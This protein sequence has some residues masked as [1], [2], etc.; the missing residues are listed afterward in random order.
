[1]RETSGYPEHIR[2]TPF[3]WLDCADIPQ[4]EWLYGR[5]LIRKYVT[6]TVAPGGLGKSSLSIVEALA[7]V[8]GRRLLHDDPHGPLRV[9]LWNGEDPIDELQR[10]VMAAARHHDISRQE[11]DGRLFL[12][13]G[14]DSSLMVA[15]VDRTGVKFAEPVIEAVVDTIRAN[16]IDVFVVDPFV[17][18]HGVPENDNGAIDRVAKTWAKIADRTGAAIH[19]IHHARKT[20]GN[21]VSIEDSR[22]AV[23][24]IGAA[25]VG[26]T[27]NPMTKDEAERAGVEQRFCY[28]RVDDGKANLAPRSEDGRWFK[29]E[30]VSL[31]YGARGTNGD[32][33]GVVTACEFPNPMDSVTVHHL[34][35]AQAAVNIGG[36]YR[37][38]IQADGWVGIPIGRAMGFDTTAGK[39]SKADAA[40]VKAALRAWI[41]SGMFEV[42][43]EDDEHRKGRKFVRVGKLAH[44]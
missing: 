9:W 16:N 29:I 43:S 34:R 11:I 10:R 23:A 42:Y 41:G 31:M 19:L 24:L 12:D 38:S 1:M 8:S 7:M 32:S 37:E 30:S 40:K 15:T 25:R 3:P 35:Q 2:A 22:G 21:E 44:D 17:S 39:L 28:V 5:A 4:R 18:S 26:R 27:L 33:V 6:V 20:R 14:R 36:P 13:S